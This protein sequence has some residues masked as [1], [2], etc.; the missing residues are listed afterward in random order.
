MIAATVFVNVLVIPERR[1]GA[2]TCSAPMF[3]VGF[4]CSSSA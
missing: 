4:R 1:D 2:A 3:Q